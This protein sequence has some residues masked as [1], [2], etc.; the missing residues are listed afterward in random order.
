M[1]AKE[2]ASESLASEQRGAE[3]AQ[4]LLALQEGE[5]PNVK[6]S[7][8]VPAKVGATKLQV[9]SSAGFLEGGTIKL[10]G[11]AGS[12]SELC[13]IAG[14]GSILL[15]SPLRFTHPI[16]TVIEQ[17]PKHV[18]QQLLKEKAAT[19]ERE[20]ASTAGSQLAESPTATTRPVMRNM[21]PE[22]RSKPVG[23]HKMIGHMSKVA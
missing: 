10:H 22:E 4:E 8:T 23:L 20:T 7:M 15:A 17:L 16:G 18:V 3:D 9:G 14:F 6:T 19:S 21:G 11:V 12:E 1:V 2:P 5:V 13:V